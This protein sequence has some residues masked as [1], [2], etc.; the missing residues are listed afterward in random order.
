LKKSLVRNTRFADK[1][2][3]LCGI[4]VG[5]WQRAATDIA[6]SVGRLKRTEQGDNPPVL[7]VSPLAHLSQH[8]LSASAHNQWA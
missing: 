6:A 1:E 8:V 5:M 7:V 4:P 2:D 3:F